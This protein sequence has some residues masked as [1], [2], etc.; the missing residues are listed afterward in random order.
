MP[1]IT[2]K[3]NLPVSLVSRWHQSSYI[4]LKASERFTFR[5]AIAFCEPVNTTVITVTMSHVS[6]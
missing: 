5:Y 6:L 4:E 1:F 2:N 3:K